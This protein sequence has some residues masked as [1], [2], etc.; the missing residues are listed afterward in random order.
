[1][2]PK[3][4]EHFL[5][6]VGQNLQY[7]MNE[8]EF[9]IEGLAEASGVSE[10]LIRLH[11]RTGRPLGSNSFVDQMEKISGRVLRPLKSGPKPIQK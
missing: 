8:R 1:M 10:K 7:L 3:G 6:L 2:S 11:G 9:T 5:W 4:Y